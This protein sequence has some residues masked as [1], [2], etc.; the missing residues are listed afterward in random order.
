MVWDRIGDYHAARFLALEKIVGEG[1]VFISD[2]GGADNLYKWKNPLSDHPCYKPLSDIPVQEAALTKR[3]GTFVSVARK[4]KIKILGL[5]GY[6]RMEYIW[7][8]FIS[9]MLGIKVI[10]FAESWYGNNAVINAL[11]GSFLNWFCKGFLVSGLRAKAHFSE[12]LGIPL[13]KIEMRYSVVDNAHFQQ[14]SKVEKE[15]ILLCVAR[16]SE[17]KNLIRLISAFKNSK[18]SN[19]WKLQIVGG[20]PLKAQLLQAIGNQANV[21]LSDWLSYSALPIL[22]AHSR[23][24][25]LP[26]TFEPW[27]LVANEAMA[28]GLPVLLSEQCGCTP[29]FAGTFDGSTFDAEDEASITF[30]I[31]KISE[32]SNAELERIGNNNQ[33]KVKNYS[34]EVWA[35]NLLNLAFG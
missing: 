28:A 6:G 35:K 30:S 25:I 20:G 17:E 8:L 5:A 10:L 16:F 24:F 13:H 1:N 22:Y 31:N 14:Q 12:K 4:N 18:I 23:V 2:L 29:D 19:S 21:Q 34:T 26:S 15:N 32:L 7:I 27:G 11:K 9:K 3:I 33:Q